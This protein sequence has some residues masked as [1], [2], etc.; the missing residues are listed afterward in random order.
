MWEQLRGDYADSP[1]FV[2]AVDE[3]LNTSPVLADD[4]WYKSLHERIKK[5][6]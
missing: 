1:E 4:E 5:T 6:D 2:A 3:A